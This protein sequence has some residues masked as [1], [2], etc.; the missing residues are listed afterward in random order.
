MMTRIFTY[1]MVEPLIIKHCGKA[2]E[3]NTF[4]LQLKDSGALLSMFNDNF[5]INMVNKPT[6]VVAG[7]NYMS[8]NRRYGAQNV[9]ALSKYGSIE[10]R[11]MKGTLEY[12]EIKFW[13]DILSTIWTENKFTN[14]SDI[15]NSYY[16]D[17]VTKYLERVFHNLPEMERFM[18]TYLTGTVREDIEENMLALLDIEE[19]MPYTWEDWERRIGKSV[20]ERGAKP[21]KRDDMDVYERLLQQARRTQVRPNMI[22]QTGWIGDG[23]TITNAT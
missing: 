21:K 22:A 1:W 4:A 5:F 12:N 13:C 6:S 14:P 7:K 15:F 3:Q 9:T 18:G 11:A 19:D 2:R 16:D 23:V 17:G 20:Y 8:T 10:Y